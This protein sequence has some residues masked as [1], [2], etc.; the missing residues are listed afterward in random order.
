MRTCDTCAKKVN[1]LECAVFTEM[2]GRNR[3]C[4]GW[5]DDPDW[6]ET[7]RM[8]VDEYAQYACED[9]ENPRRRLTKK[10]KKLLA[11]IVGIISISR[12]EYLA[13][14]ETLCLSCT[15]SQP[16]TCSFWKEEDAERG[17]EAMGASAVKTALKYKSKTNKEV[18]Y[19]VI[20]CPH[21]ER[22]VS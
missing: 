7:I 14:S 5:T 20:G 1:K 10:Q 6:R 11:E 8:A 22:K 18:V 3:D 13:L 4:F 9:E 12:K 17:L 16:H 19:K 2:F 15:K 21:F